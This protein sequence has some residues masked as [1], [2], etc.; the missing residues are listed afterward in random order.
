[1]AVSDKPARAPLGFI[2]WAMLVYLVFVTV[3]AL[4]R[5]QRKPDGIWVIVANLLTFLL[6]WLLHQPGLGRFGRIMRDIYP[7]MLLPA[8]YGALDLLNGPD[9][10]TWDHQIQRLEAAIFG[11]QVSREWWQAYP[12]RFWSTLLHATY[13]SYYLIVPFPA[14]F[15]LSRG[16]PDRARRAVELVVATFLFCYAV[17]LLFPVAGPYYEFS[18]PTGQFVDNWAA[19]LVYATLDR[20]SSFGAAFPSSHVAAT[21]ASTIATWQGSRKAG[22]ILVVPTL[23]LTLAVVYCQMHYMVDA[24][25]GLLLPL[26][27]AALMNAKRRRA[28]ARTA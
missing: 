9:L 20:G 7:V 6:I 22:L 18:R 5:L 13:F 28:D 15:F 4:T 23:L 19:R 26:P 25:T 11:M 2:D 12:S 21:F 8:L 27:I 16:Q 3:V 10:G 1:M 14:I 24:I 17:F